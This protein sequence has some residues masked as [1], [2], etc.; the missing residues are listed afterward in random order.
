VVRT[1]D[2]CF[3]W[4]SAAVGAGGAGAVLLLSLGGFAFASRDRMR[5]AR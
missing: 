5:V 2:E 3:D 1:I 4:G